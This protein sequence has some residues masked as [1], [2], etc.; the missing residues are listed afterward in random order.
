MVDLF[1]HPP[2]NLARAQEMPATFLLTFS[3]VRGESPFIFMDFLRGGRKSRR[4]ADEIYVLPANDFESAIPR[5]KFHS[6]EW[7][8]TL[9]FDISNLKKPTLRFEFNNFEVFEWR[10]NNPSRR[11]DY[12]LPNHCIFINKN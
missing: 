8:K 5:Q 7:N 2:P 9:S 1:P 11:P 3:W 4:E 6:I 10:M 12:S